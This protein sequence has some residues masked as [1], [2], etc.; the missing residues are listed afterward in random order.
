MLNAR[1]TPSELYT[2]VDL[3]AR[4]EGSSGP[5]LTGICFEALC[6]ALSRAG[7]AARRGDRQEVMN[8]LSRAA[9]LLGGLQN[10]VDPEAEMADVL[11]DFYGSISLRLRELIQVPSAQ[12][13]DEI[14]TDVEEVAPVL[15]PN[16]AMT[17]S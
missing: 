7:L 9:N 11:I 13:I 12:A 3:H 4:I 10:A 2:R 14:R 15:A 16:R 6:S 1:L 17:A 8:G 5:E